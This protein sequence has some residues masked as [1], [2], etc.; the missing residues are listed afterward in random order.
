MAK[1]Q[2]E[3]NTTT[4]VMPVRKLA[5]IVTPTYDIP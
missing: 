3:V 5:C 4:V 1:A 2:Q